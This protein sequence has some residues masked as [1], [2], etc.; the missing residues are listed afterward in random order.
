MS[1]NLT[2]AMNIAGEAS[3]HHF[4]LQFYDIVLN[5]I[6]IVLKELKMFK[7]HSVRSPTLHDKNL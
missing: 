3:N 2:S 7:H 1:K 5:R 6:V 4:A